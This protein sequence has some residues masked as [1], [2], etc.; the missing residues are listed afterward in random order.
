MN[1]QE[2]IEAFAARLDVSP[3]ADEEV[4]QILELAAIAAHA[5]ERIAAPVACWLAARSGTELA[6]ALDRAG[7]V[8]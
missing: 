8:D 5:S 4:E 2:W 6:D 1:A 3:P 7:G